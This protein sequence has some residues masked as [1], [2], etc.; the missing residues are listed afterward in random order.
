MNKHLYD[1]LD[2]IEGRKD[3]SYKY[4]KKLRKEEKK[5]GK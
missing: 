3:S 4:I 2:K 5:K 1:F